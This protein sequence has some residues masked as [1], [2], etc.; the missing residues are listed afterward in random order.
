MTHLW[1]SEHLFLTYRIADLGKSE[2]KEKL[3]NVKGRKYSFDTFN[4]QQFCSS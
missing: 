1:G 2:G 3:L 4:L